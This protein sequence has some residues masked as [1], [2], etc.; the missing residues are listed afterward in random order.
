MSSSWMPLRLHAAEKWIDM[1]GLWRG[2]PSSHAIAQKMRRDTP[3]GSDAP[4]PDLRMHYRH[5]IHREI[6]QLAMCAH[7]EARPGNAST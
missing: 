6:C 2:C 4:H 3:F 1:N 5:Q 7:I